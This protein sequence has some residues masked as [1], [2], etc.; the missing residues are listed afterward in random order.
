MKVDKIGHK[1]K[2]KG[3]ILFFYDQNLETE[4]GGTADRHVYAAG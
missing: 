1:L 4:A 3:P 2:A